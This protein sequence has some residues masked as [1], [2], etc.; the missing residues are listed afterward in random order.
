MDQLEKTDHNDEL[1]RIFSNVSHELR[2]PLNGLLGYARIGSRHA[3]A[4]NLAKTCEYIDK[5]EACGQQLADK[6]ND[7]LHYAQP[8]LARPRFKKNDLRD[9]VNG[10]VLAENALFR[11]QNIRV[12]I[13][14]D[15][16]LVPVV[17]CDAD[18]IRDV[19][20]KIIGNAVRFSEPSSHIIIGFESV[21]TERGRMVELAV[22]DFGKGISDADA[23]IVF[24]PL[25]EGAEQVRN[26]GG[27]GM[28]L[29]VCRKVI[30]MHE[31]RIYL[32]KTED[33]KVGCCVALTLPTKSD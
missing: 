21:L 24:D 20:L 23:Q 10:A 7:L 22:T 3:R 27:W 16:T 29:A 30:E 18:L 2:T 8:E 32:K 28:G 17:L 14:M 26:S 25:R 5:I 31:G 6:I 15:A 13:S 33:S 1:S 4:G 9:I 11:E 19:L 12:A